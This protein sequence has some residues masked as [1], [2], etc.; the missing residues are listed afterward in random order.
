MVPDLLPFN[1]PLML[2]RSLAVNAFLRPRPETHAQVEE[3]GDRHWTIDLD[4]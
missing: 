1:Q 3:I 2:C 4:C